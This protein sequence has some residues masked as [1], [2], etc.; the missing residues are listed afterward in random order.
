MERPA[1]RGRK[2]FVRRSSG[3]DTAQVQQPPA[4]LLRE[5][6]KTPEMPSPDVPSIPP[7]EASL[8]L[9]PS[10]RRSVSPPRMAHVARP[11]SPERYPRNTGTELP[12]R[13]PSP[14]IPKRHLH[15]GLVQRTLIGTTE[16]L[17]LIHI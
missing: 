13:Q 8:D 3:G 12:L 11:V 5:N 17:S 16:E 4:S 10:P 2:V 14:V 9:L 6:L 15:G 7:S 1:A